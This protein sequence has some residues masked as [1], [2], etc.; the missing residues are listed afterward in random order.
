M[1]G[2]YPYG[3]AAPLTYTYTPEVHIQPPT[4]LGGY[5]YNLAASTPTVYTPE[6]YLCSVVVIT[7]K[8]SSPTGLKYLRETTKVDLLIAVLRI[9]F[10]FSDTDPGDPKRP[11]PDPT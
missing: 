8:F 10:I 11:D 4:L 6:K 5:P 3:L 9:R 2:G 7:T 1:L